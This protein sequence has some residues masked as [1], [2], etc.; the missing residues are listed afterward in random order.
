MKWL[1][2]VG[3]ILLAVIIFVFWYFFIGV[4]S[5]QAGSFY[6]NGN[7]AVWLE[8]E[9]VDT[10]KSEKEIFELVENLKKHQIGTVFVHAGPLKPD[11]TIEPATYRYAID[12][13]EK[14][15]RFNSEIQYQAW[16]GQIRGKIDLSREEVR[17][18]VAKQTLILAE[19]LDFDGVHFDIEPVWD[20]DSEFI[21]LLKETREMLPE[22]KKISVALA[23]FIPKSLLFV[24]KAFHEFEN[25][26]SEVNYENV[27]QYADE[28]VVMTYATGFEHEWLYR[29]LVKEQT[30]WVTDL[31]RDKK[32]FVG[33][34]AYQQSI[35]DPEFDERIENMENGLRGLI[36]GLNNFR[37]HE[38]SFEGVAIYPY[39]EIDEA[40]WKIYD[41]LWLK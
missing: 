21:Q 22:E 15:R 24:G 29:W 10:K 41:D 18:S 12:F 35:N 14:A 28:I 27:A 16:L 40:E 2:N 8:H 11:G 17:H 23:E 38:E 9:W 13:L 25:F 19:F 7:N 34:P 39:W 4:S 30:I 6:N 1:K 31:I 36:S 3:L 5:N 33:I 26:N 20:G 37:S 32:V